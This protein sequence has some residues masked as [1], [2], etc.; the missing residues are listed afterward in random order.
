MSDAIGLV[1]LGSIFHFAPS[2][3]PGYANHQM[4]S[5]PPL[6][7]FSLLFYILTF[8][9]LS[10]PDLANGDSRPLGEHASCN[11]HRSKFLEE[12]FRS[13]WDMNL[14]DSLLVLARAAFKVLG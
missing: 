2:Q 8:R 10:Q 12:Q 7:P 1:L 3:T 4:Y 14:R 6:F 13:V 5:L 9:A 11:I